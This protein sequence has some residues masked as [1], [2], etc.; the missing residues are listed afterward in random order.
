MRYSGIQP[1]YFP[2]LHY[3]A[4]I[5]NADIFIIRDD[6]QFVRHHKYPD[7]KI[8]PSY[9]V[10]SSIKSPQGVY[11]IVVPIV[12]E[13][14]T[15]INKT[16]ITYQEKWINSHVKTI[17]SLYGRALNFKTIFPEIKSI[18]EKRHDSLL[19]LNLKTVL[20]GVLR[21]LGEEKVRD[22]KLTIEYINKKLGRSPKFRLKQIKLAT[23]LESFKKFKNMTGNEKII[24]ICKELGV[25]EDYCGGTAVAAYVDESLF[26]KNGIKI[27]VQDW[28][29][30]KYPQLFEDKVGF[31]ENISII[32]LLMNVPRK[33]AVRIING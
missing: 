30:Q 32:D 25:T 21:L 22:D 23:N 1:Q 16:H 15:A 4:R 5:L 20:W 2:R 29:C 24:A 7:G 19:E 31:I 33:E 10:R 17:Q 27:T 26:K 12:H 8:G 28:K 3:F 14:L 6:V 11:H 18:V 13:G 9:Q